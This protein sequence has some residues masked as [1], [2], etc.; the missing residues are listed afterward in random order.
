MF[1]SRLD[2]DTNR[3][4]LD[5][6]SIHD[7]LSHKSTWAWLEF[8]PACGIKPSEDANCAPALALF[9]ESPQS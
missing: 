2:I 6:A 1:M 5:R 7:F 4:H 3:A 9:A 8:G